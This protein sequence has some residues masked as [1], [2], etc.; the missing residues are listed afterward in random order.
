MEPIFLGLFVAL[1]HMQHL[2]PFATPVKK[3]IIVEI[4]PQKKQPR[5]FH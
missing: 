2:R 1:D 3:K 4:S 5:Y